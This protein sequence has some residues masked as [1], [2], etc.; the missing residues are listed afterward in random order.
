M[1]K[2]PPHALSTPPGAFSW[3]EGLETLSENGKKRPKDGPKLHRHS[4]RQLGSLVLTAV[5]DVAATR[6]HG[7]LVEVWMRGEVVHLDVLH[8]DRLADLAISRAL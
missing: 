7:K 1:S 6:D 3:S 2:A 5:V 4:L 8:V